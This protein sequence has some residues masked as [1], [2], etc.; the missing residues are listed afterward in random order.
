M[1]LINDHYVQLCICD[2]M[3][4]YS[5]VMLYLQIL[6]TSSPLPLISELEHKLGNSC[7]LRAW[8]WEGEPSFH[9]LLLRKWIPTYKQAGRGGGDDR[10]SDVQALSQDE[11]TPYAE[12]NITLEDEEASSF[13]IFM[14][15]STLLPCLHLEARLYRR[16]ISISVR[17]KDR[18]VLM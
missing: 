18:G 17:L 8:W 4:Q 10:A 9:T 15:S 2:F 1:E 13:L 16:C 7:L 14:S 5:S 12:I 6:L 3:F 11:C